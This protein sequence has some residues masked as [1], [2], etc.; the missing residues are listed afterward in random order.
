[1]KT[2]LT[3]HLLGFLIERGYTYCLAKTQTTFKATASVNITLTPVKVKPKLESLPAGY[4]TYFK[5]TREPMQMACGIDDTE[6][7]ITLD[8]KQNKHR[9]QD[10]RISENR[11]KNSFVY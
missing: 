3:P 1:M 10:E 7:Y 6:V 4:D 5:I 9:I 11:S 8:L 2:V